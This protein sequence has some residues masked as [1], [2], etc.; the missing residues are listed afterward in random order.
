MKLCIPQAPPGGLDEPIYGHFGSAPQFT[1]VD[2]D[3]RAVIEVVH[4]EPHRAHGACAPASRVLDHGADAVVCSGLG[5]RALAKLTEAGM[6]V[7]ITEA[8]T[9]A[10]AVSEVVSGDA[11]E[12]T[13]ESACAGHHS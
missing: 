9:A 6:R 11:R 1:V 5:R 8:A 10:E 3:T 4:T 13:E 12:C 7:F 2:T